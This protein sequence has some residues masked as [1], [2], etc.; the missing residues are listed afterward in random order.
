MDIAQGIK[1][2]ERLANAAQT[3]RTLALPGEPT[4]KYLIVS[5][6]GTYTAHEPSRP[7]HGEVLASP[8]ELRQF[9][10]SLRNSV[11]P[12]EADMVFY[13]EARVVYVYDFQQRRDRAV[14]PLAK[15]ET[16][17][18]VEGLVGHH[19]FSQR[20]IVRLLRVTLREGF[21]NP[22]L[23]QMLR[24][25]KWTNAGEAGASLQV[26]R[27]SLGRQVVQAVVGVD[28]M[29]D[30]VALYVRVY[31]GLPYRATVRCY[32]EADV[33]AQR[34]TFVPFPGEIRAAVDV[35]L[36][37]I[38]ETELSS[39]SGKHESM[40]PAFRGRVGVGKT[41]AQSDD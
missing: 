34:F 8:A 21:D 3:L 7:L 15:S 13:D 39:G 32:L 30:E 1:E 10:L 12:P 14:C 25:V 41:A 40:P 5:P 17:R 37:Q 38:H 23:L 26:G 18:A 22:G 36:G 9:I 19:T 4:G 6:D 11:Q 16:M 28:A 27:E 20:E 33:G 29:P 24:E 31:E 35:A 2:I